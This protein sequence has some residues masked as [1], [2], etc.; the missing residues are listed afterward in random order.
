MGIVRASHYSCNNASKNR[1]VKL[2]PVLGM[3][4]QSEGLGTAAVLPDRAPAIG[5]RAQGVKKK[6]HTEEARKE[7]A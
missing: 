2:E 5:P 1:L 3:F 7:A 4:R 6:R